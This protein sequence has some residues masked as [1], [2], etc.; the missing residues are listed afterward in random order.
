MYVEQ[1]TY[2]LKPGTLR[3]YLAVYEAEGLPISAASSDGWW[4]TTAASPGS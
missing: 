4:A 2:T 1:R 3:D